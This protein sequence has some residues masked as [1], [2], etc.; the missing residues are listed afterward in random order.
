MIAAGL[1]SLQ[2]LVGPYL[3]RQDWFRATGAAPPSKSR[4]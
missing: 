4:A 2:P 3:A 1:E